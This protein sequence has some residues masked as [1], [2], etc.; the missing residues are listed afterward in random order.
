MKKQSS[1][2][3][4]II[5]MMQ[6]QKTFYGTASIPITLIEQAKAMHQEEIKEAWLDGYSCGMYQEESSNE[7][8]NEIFKEDDKRI[9]D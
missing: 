9:G 7:Y 4:L 5:E 1:I 2:E 6:H 3:W 8:Y